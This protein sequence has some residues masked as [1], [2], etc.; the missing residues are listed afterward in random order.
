MAN[1]IAPAWRSI[2]RAKEVGVE[3][4]G[5]GLL[6]FMTVTSVVGWGATDLEPVGIASTVGGSMMVLMF[7]FGDTY[8]GYFN[9]AVTIGLLARG[10]I[11]IVRAVQYMLAQLV[12]AVVGAALARACI[13]D[14]M[15]SGKAV[16]LLSIGYSRKQAFVAE[17]IVTAF[18]VATFV[19]MLDWR[20]NMTVPRLKPLAPIA[21]GGAV[22]VAHLALVPI[23]GCALNPARS[24]GAGIAAWSIRPPGTWH[25]MWIFI[26]APWLGGS[27]AGAVLGRISGPSETDSHSS[28]CMNDRAD[29]LTTSPTPCSP[30]FG[31]AS[32]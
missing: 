26:A 15:F 6:L 11:D 22:F 13:H 9:C 19:L 5:T 12:G 31:K 21:V 28:L 4:L 3:F 29:V 30:K 10:A 18:L 20:Q 16:N 2:Q 25:Q 8:G 17:F 1:V 32:V 7:A 27:V 14:Y 23:D 24:V